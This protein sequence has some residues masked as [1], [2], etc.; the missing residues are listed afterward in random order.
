M[1]RRRS[2][3]MWTTVL[4]LALAASLLAGCQRQEGQQ[5]GAPT[6]APTALAAAPPTAPTTA[7]A[8]PAA[9]T[10][11]P[12]EAGPTPMPTPGPGQFVNPVVDMDFPDPDTLKVG[13]T[14]YAYATN[15]NG[16]NIQGASSTDLVNWKSFGETL[17]ALPL[18]AKPVAG[19]TWAPEVTA[20]ADGKT[21][22][23]YFTSRD[24]ATD[25]QCV[26]VATSDKPDGVFKAVGDKAF[27][28]QADLGGTIDASSFVDDDGS[29]YV[30]FKNDGN[31]CGFAT[32]LWI[33]KVSADGLTLEGQPTA[34]IE[35]D[36]RWEG[37]VVEAPTLWKHGGKYYLFYSANNYAGMDYCIG[38]AVADSIL[39]PY[40]KPA[41]G[42][43]VKTSLKGSVVIGPGGQDITVDKQGQTWLV[44][45]SWNLTIDY[46]WMN[47]D[48]LDWEGDVPVLRGP[49][50]IPEP[51]P[52]MK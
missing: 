34:L 12:T 37:Q 8:A 25:K 27:I 20:S 13:D 19:L 49:N 23:M 43:W 21:F 36:Q 42:P 18:W 28:C 29:R 17:P 40:K 26:G 14:Y 44:Y 9:P 30:L 32:R 51:A 39:G 22:I 31:C 45:H 10:A 16:A 1:Q 11:A 48:R 2:L 7:P 4:A 24:Q 5:G 47:I 38:Y 15:A 46:R 3:F 41:N 50:R 52:A 6:A 33:Q 35:N